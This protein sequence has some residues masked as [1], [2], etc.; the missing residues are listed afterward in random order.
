MTDRLL[1]EPLAHAPLVLAQGQ[2]AS[3]FDDRLEQDRVV[4][5]R[6]WLGY[7]AVRSL[8]FGRS[9]L[10]DDSFLVGPG[11]APLSS[12]TSHQDANWKRFSRP[13]KLDVAIGKAKPQERC[14][15]CAVIGT[16][17]RVSSTQPQLARGE[18]EH[19]QPRFACSLLGGSAFRRLPGE[20]NLHNDRRRVIPPCCDLPQLAVAT[21]RVADLRRGP[22]PGGI[23]LEVTVRKTHFEGPTRH[24]REIP[25]GGNAKPGS[26]SWLH[27]PLAHAPLV[28]SEQN[29]AE[30]GEPA[31]RILQ[32]AQ[33]LLT[34][35]GRQCD[36]DAIRVKRRSQRRCRRLLHEVSE[37]VNEVG[38]KRN[39]CH[40][41]HEVDLRG[42]VPQSALVLGK[43]HAPKLSQ[44]VGRI[45]EHEQDRLAIGN[46]ERDEVLLG[47]ERDEKRIA[48]VL[49]A[50]SEQKPSQVGNVLFADGNAGEPHGADATRRSGAS[51]G[52]RFA[53]I[54]PV[55]KFAAARERGGFFRGETRAASISFPRDPRAKRSWS[56][57]DRER[58]GPAGRIPG[59]GSTGIATAG[60][61]RRRDSD[62]SRLPRQ[63]WRG[64]HTGWAARR[65]ISI[66]LA[67]ERTNAGSGSRRRADQTHG[68]AAPRGRNACR[69]AVPNDGPDRH[70]VASLPEACL[71][72]GYPTRQPA[73]RQPLERV[74]ERLPELLDA[75]ALRL[76]LGVTRA[77][78]EAIM[79]RLP[80][81]QIEGLR[82]V[83]VRRSD[84]VAYLETRT[85]TKAEVPS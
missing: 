2:S 59:E 20:F 84:V 63:Q 78:A 55:V 74:T 10:E 13:A 32:A 67:G 6:R 85:F 3:D 16:H 26:R 79:R 75:R 53:R 52:G 69:Q 14:L 41:E 38:R 45:I 82:K 33:E 49:E 18:Q 17:N 58:G 50:R 30:L 22:V 24:E 65:G 7:G 37:R 70:Q 62:R 81:V 54:S 72:P 9:R 60:P 25:T 23:D 8:T 1:N 77:S 83:Y 71:R 28:L 44:S 56:C 34:L 5:E 31:G 4:P 48:G 43:E 39:A 35:A 76:E 19:T 42:S 46:R 21:D 11:D 51:N 80:T 12:P 47:V 64:E 27:E 57:A 66:A 61:P 29:S 73:K 68:R 15:R 40:D 36:S